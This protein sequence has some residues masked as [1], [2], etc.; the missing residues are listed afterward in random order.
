MTEK[1]AKKVGEAYAFAQVL[2]ETFKNNSEVM[3]EL[4][5]EHAENI[6]DITR[7]Q[8]EELKDIAEESDMD[9]VVLPKSERTAEKITKMGDMYVG[10]DWDDA[11]EVLEWMSFFVGGAIVHW[12]LITGSAEKMDND[13]FQNVTGVGTE[14]YEALMKQ[15]K[16][17][18]TKIGE[19]RA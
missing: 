4:L 5:G 19:E 17:S 2:S 18:A 11:A 15:L 14:Y 10:D 13:H 7:V 12:Q 1:V 8:M 6:E 3:S 9:E 16:V